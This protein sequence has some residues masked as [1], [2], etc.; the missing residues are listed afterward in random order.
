MAVKYD[1]LTG[2][3]RLQTAIEIDSAKV[4]VITVM[5][6]GILDI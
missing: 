1:V 4:W 3:N 2:S 6:Q 5:N